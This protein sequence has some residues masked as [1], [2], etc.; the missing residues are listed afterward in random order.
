[1]KIF[2]KNPVTTRNL[3]NNNNETLD[4]NNT[5]DFDS[6][7]NTYS[8]NKSK[9]KHNKSNNTTNKSN[10]NNKT[11][12]NNNKANTKNISSENKSNKKRI[13]NSKNSK[14]NNQKIDNNSRNNPSSNRDTKN[15]NDDTQ[16]SNNK[17]QN[18]SDT[19]LKS[20]ET[21]KDNEDH[22]KKVTRSVWK[23]L[24]GDKIE[25]YLIRHEQSMGDYNQSMYTL[26]TKDNSQIIVWGKTQ[27]DQLIAEVD[28]DD[29][30]RITYTGLKK[31]TNGREMMTFDL[32]KWEEN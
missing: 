9:N 6:K 25:G 19:T 15:S 24:V 31:T 26:E 27:L 7:I 22:W 13:S 23:P 14:Q 20:N 5:R 30:I 4:N 16:T 17:T 11:N 18:S 1:M 28:I 10:S 3:E 29:Y 2:N 32:D 12:L 21:Q 8:Y